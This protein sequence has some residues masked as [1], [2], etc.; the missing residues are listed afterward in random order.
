MVETLTDK[1]LELEEEIQQLKETVQDLVSICGYTSTWT[2]LYTYLLTSSCLHINFQECGTVL[3]L[4]LHVGSS[5]RVFGGF[6]NGMGV[7]LMIMS[8]KLKLTYHGIYTDVLKYILHESQQQKLSIDRKA[9]NGQ[10][11]YVLWWNCCSKLYLYCNFL[12]FDVKLW[13]L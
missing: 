12:I 13:S 10:L 11:M 1:N 7:W 2:A 4:G 3:P 9:C 5:S 8:E 6:L